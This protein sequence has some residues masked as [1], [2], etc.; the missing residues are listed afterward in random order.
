MKF[1]DRLRDIIEHNDLTRE[2]LAKIL[3]ITRQCLYKYEYG[4]RKPTLE[5]LELMAD[6]FDLSTDYLLGRI[7][8][9]KPQ[10]K[11]FELLESRFN[12][13]NDALVI[14]Q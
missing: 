1:S 2:E 9:P 13:I 5:V 11:N 10:E 4:K 6:Y 7:N 12:E 8:D 14:D 3:K